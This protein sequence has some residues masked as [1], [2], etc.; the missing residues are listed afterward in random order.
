MENG[1]WATSVPTCNLLIAILIFAQIPMMFGQ[2]GADA[3]I[4][5]LPW[6]LA[7]Y[8]VILICIIIMYKNGDFV[9]ATMNAIL[10]GVIMGQNF[11]RGIMA[12][13]LLAA[14]Q[15]IAPELTASGFAIDAWVYLLT[16][17]ILMV[18]G[19]L[20]HF[21]SMLAGIGVWS[22]SVGFFALSAMYAGF[23]EICGFVSG[24]GL[25]ILAVYFLY[26]GLVGLVNIAVGKDVRHIK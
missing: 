10:S 19:W 2:A 7:A 13:T 9:D 15:E 3:V 25:T 8:P 17:I 16:G 12:L 11:V 26:A 1:K 5:T 20:A 21:G 22:G 6:V 24:I 23:G 18:A 4:Y 14:G